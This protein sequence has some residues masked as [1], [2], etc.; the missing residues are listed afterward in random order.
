MKSLAFLAAAFISLTAFSV[1]SLWK[2]DKMHS[3]LG[4]TVKHL[5]IAEID[6]TFNDFE[7]TIVSNKEDFS[8]AQISMVA[9][10]ASIYTRVEMRDNHLR[11]ADFFD[12]QKFPEITF[13]STS[14]R[15]DDDK[16]EYIVTGDLTIKGI[17]KRVELELEFNGTA[18]NPQSNQK[19]AGFKIEGEINRLDFGV[20]VNFP[21]AMISE[22]I[23]I[24]AHGEFTK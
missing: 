19:T 24:E 10:A 17:T 15:P 22:K 12:V 21:D 13:K 4:F 16:N 11:S 18:I 7:A 14:I 5:G 8:D 6:G 9:K 23:E 3:Q 20:G 2:A 1:S